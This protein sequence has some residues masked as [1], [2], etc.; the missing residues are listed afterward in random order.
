ML[1]QFSVVS[2]VIMVILALV[3]SFV[4]V[5]VLN[6][7]IGLLEGVREIE[8]TAHEFAQSVGAVHV[9]EVV[10]LPILDS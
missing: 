4:F 6:R 1:V 3:I 5:E 2:F 7:N 10:D 8:K 9:P